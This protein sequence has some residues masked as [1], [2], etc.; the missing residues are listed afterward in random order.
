[1]KDMDLRP[2]IGDIACPTLVLGGAEDPVT[3]TRCSNEIA[4]AIGTNARL[5]IFDNC[6]HG[7]H[8][9]DPDGA[10]RLM[11]GFLAT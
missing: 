8:R 7:V 9:D 10:E 5:E 6:G 11:R 2:G 3:P 1:M 4:E